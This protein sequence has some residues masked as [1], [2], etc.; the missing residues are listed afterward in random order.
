MSRLRAA[1]AAL[2]LT[3]L[4]ASCAGGPSRPTV[5]LNPLNAAAQNAD[6]VSIRAQL[7]EGADPCAKDVDGRS[8][9]SRLFYNGGRMAD[10]ILPAAVE[11]GCPAA[12]YF[13]AALGRA[14]S[15]RD[16]LAKGAPARG[17]DADWRPIDGA[18]AG[19]PGAGGETPG[20]VE[21]A[22]MLLDAGVDPNARRE[23][24]YSP[25][26]FAITNNHPGVAKLLLERGAN[27]NDE[28]YQGEPLLGKAASHGHIATVRLMLEKGADPEPAIAALERSVTYWQGKLSRPYAGVYEQN[29]LQAA[30]NSIAL[31]QRLAAERRAPAAAGGTT[32]EEL[33]SIV[34]AAVEK[35]SAKRVTA[36]AP[37]EPSSDVDQPS[38]RRP[39]RPSDLAVV[40]GVTKYSDLVEAA[41]G[42]RDA[43]AVKNHLIAQGFPSR[44]VV[45]LSGEKASR[46]AIEKFVETWL[47]RNVTSDSRV[48]FYFSGHGAPDPVS[49]KTYL[50]PWDGDPG[51]LENT[52]Y[53]IARLYEKLGALESRSV[54]VALD[55]CFSGSGGRSVLAKGARPLVAHVASAAVPKNLT[56][57]AAAAGNEIA[58]TA[59]EQGHGLFTYHLLKGLTSAARGADGV[60]SARALHEYLT[61]K[62]QDAARR[63]NRSQTPTLIGEAGLEVAR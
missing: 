51:F 63:Q 20:H 2:P 11:R 30:R 14:E 33:A 32:R 6:A 3:L 50:V 62:V 59:D 29:Q 44:N 26:H 55:A 39:A 8:A 47:P 45:L 1:L 22:R 48:V 17:V 5:V 49:G 42:E 52:A 13:A 41:Y 58:S 10:A 43:E 7:K 46:S 24:G 34:A 38:Y 12:L 28:G 36:G 25:L 56:V 31:I 60:L 27:P 40:V 23:N 54:L 61:P 21:A 57:L 15:V 35:A 18:A 37:P 9:V 19:L 16:L 4:L 53:P